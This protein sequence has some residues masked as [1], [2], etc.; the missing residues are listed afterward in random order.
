[1][2]NMMKYLTP[3][4]L[5]AGE[6]IAG[7]HD[8]FDE[9]NNY[10]GMQRFANNNMGLQQLPQ[11]GNNR[12]IGR[13]S[14]LEAIG[15]AAQQVAGAYMNKALHDKYGDILEKAGD[16]RKKTYRDM[17]AKYRADALRNVGIEPFDNAVY[18]AV[19]DQIDP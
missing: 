7:L 18:G 16:N 13:N 10:A 8:P 17:T 3:E 4:D 9:I 15:G 12:V 1:M 5:V 19:A 6:E 14:V 11:Y 2:N